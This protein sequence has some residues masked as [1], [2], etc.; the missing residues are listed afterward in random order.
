[1]K[2]KSAQEFS[3]DI[4]KLSFEQA[5]ELLEEI[6]RKLESGQSSLDESINDYT[7]G[8]ELKNYCMQKLSNAK[9]KVEKIIQHADNK[10]STETFDAE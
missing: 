9:L 3:S 2:S 1:M 5:L 6:V 7:R 10:V 4:I 8:T